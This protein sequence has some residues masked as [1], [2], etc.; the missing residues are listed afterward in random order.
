MPRYQLSG[1]EFTKIMLSHC[2][3]F[4]VSLSSCTKRGNIQEREEE[5]MK[6]VV[7]D[8]QPHPH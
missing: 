2:C 1:A 8:P 3:M 4:L 5:E 6:K 7:V